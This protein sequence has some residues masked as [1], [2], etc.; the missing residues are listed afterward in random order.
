MQ[1]TKWTL[2]LATSL[3][4]LALA[5]SAES[6]TAAE[7]GARPAPL[8]KPVTLRLGLFKGAYTVAF[9]DVPALL[10]GSN[11]KLEISNFV[12]YADARTALAN[13][14][15]DVATISPGDLLVALSQGVTS[16]VGLTGVATSTRYFVVRNGI[17]IKD[18][19]DLVGK[20]IGIAPGSSSWFQFTAKLM[21]VGLPYSKLTTA[22]I[23]GA[24]SNF[25]IALK[26]G[27]I[28]VAL[29]W[30]PFESEPII[31]GYGYWPKA[32]DYSDSKAVGNDT[33]AI[34]A[35]RTFLKE[36]REAVRLLLWAFLKSESQLKADPKRYEMVIQ[37]YTGATPAVAEQIAAK[38]KLGGSLDVS[39]LERYAKT[40]HAVG[41]LPKDVSGE[42]ANA[43]DPSLKNSLNLV[44]ESMKQ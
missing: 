17:E 34:A 44:K 31:E 20:K 40:F 32:L 35:S 16:I 11:L 36:Q 12:R 24:G 3:I 42:V 37:K 7:I 1:I 41:A 8:E 23:Q 14:S 21:D 19:S 15:L 5:F 10:E 4:V 33:G 38:I 25:L 26:R 9:E 28:D 22:N 27:D 39:Q 43:F 6:A 2:R 30:E 18:W 13:G 29:T